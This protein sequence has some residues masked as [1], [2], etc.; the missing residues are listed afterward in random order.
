MKDYRHYPI[1]YSMS[2]K[3]L[4]Y[5]RN[6]GLEV[7]LV[8]LYRQALAIIIGSTFLYAFLAFFLAIGGR[9]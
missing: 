3:W 8:S 6:L 4:I 5:L 7:S 2:P 9:P 1:M